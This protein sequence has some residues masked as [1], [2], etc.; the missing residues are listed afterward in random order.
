MDNRVLHENVINIPA[1]LAAN[2]EVFSDV[3]HTNAQLFAEA[4][5]SVPDVSLLG[6]GAGN[7]SVTLYGSAD[8]V[9]FFPEGIAT[10][11]YSGTP[12]AATAVAVANFAPYVKVGIKSAATGGLEAGHGIKVDLITVEKYE[13]YKRSYDYSS[14]G[15]AVVT[16]TVTA[17]ATSAGTV[18]VTLPGL[19]AVETELLLTDDLVG[20]VATKIGAG[21][22]TGWTASVNA[23]VVTFTKNTFGPITGTPVFTDVD[24]TGAAATVVVTNNGDAAAY[25]SAPHILEKLLV[26]SYDV[27]TVSDFDYD[28]YTSNDMVTWYKIRTQNNVH[29]ASFDTVIDFSGLG[30]LKYAKVEPVTVAGTGTVNVGLIG[31]GY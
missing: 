20:E 19:A 6:S 26:A 15:E 13:D 22:Y 27:G 4:F 5:V 31:L 16:L 12:A 9:T 1:T 11:A 10:V 14:S 7:L 2:A 3:Y 24:T 8:G 30:L 28:V 23:A 29:T 21:T 18:S 25:V 17:G